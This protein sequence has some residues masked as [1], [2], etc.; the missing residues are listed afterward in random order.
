[1]RSLFPLLTIF[2]LLL[3]ACSGG[4]GAASSSPAPASAT[5]PAPDGGE[6]ISF[7]FFGPLTGPTSGA[8]QALQQ[9]ALLQ[10]QQ[11]NEAG[12]VLGRQIEL[13]SCDDKS[14][15]EE[16]V[17]C[18]QRL[19]DQDGVFAI[20]GSLH[21]PHIS[22]TGPIVDEAQVPMVGAGTGPGWCEEGFQFVWRGTANSEQSTDALAGV[23]EG[24]GIQR[25]GILYQ[26]DDY[27]SG[28]LAALQG[29]LPDAD[30][31][32]EESY[33]LGDRDWSGQIIKILAA[34]PDAIAVW[35]LGDDLGAL[36][37]QIREQGWT[38]AIIGAEGYTLPQ[39]VEGAGENVNG[40]VFSQLYYI[41]AA[42]SDYPDPTIRAF[43][44]AYETEYGEL[45]ASDNA[46]RGADA[47]LILTT[48][49]EQAGELDPEKV[50]EA[51]AGISELEGLAGSF[52]FAEGGCE[53]IEGS[54]VWTFAD[55]AI[56]PF[57]GEWT[58]Q[59]G[60]PFPV[61]AP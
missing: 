7:G 29:S 28:G 46:Y 56:V 37:N 13:I 49:I 38:G 47:V 48:G 14:T 44:E 61:P 6:T 12:G 27:G 40:V 19:T 42:A 43:L 51:I 25:I 21:S 4:G 54:R 22:A 24:S 36:T 5:E 18:A 33:T 35:A 1:M 59:D 2:A 52:N 26:N 50:Q 45:P 60:Q 10:I 34:E 8:G 53:G 16:A 41:P 57:E 32:A 58:D 11:L 3:A 15:P 39:V 9:G 23:L 17:T 20:V 30:I 55:G 31:V